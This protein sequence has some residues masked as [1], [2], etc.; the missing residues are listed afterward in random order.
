MSVANSKFIGVLMG[1]DIDFHAAF[2]SFPPE[3]RSEFVDF[4]IGLHA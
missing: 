4:L 3:E 1:Q 2:L